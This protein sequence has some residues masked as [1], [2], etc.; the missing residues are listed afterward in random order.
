MVLLW[1]DIFQIYPEGLKQTTKTASVKWEVH[2]ENG[3]SWAAILY[4]ATLPST[5]P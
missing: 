4:S 1:V 2:P 5:S 3:L